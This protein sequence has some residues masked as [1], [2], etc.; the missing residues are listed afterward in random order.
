M[1]TN[2]SD[3]GAMVKASEKQLATAGRILKSNVTEKWSQI[4]KA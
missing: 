2:D 4:T 1:S 3:N